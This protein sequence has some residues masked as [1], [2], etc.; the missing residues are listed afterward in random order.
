MKGPIYN[1]SFAFAVRV[2]KLAR[3]LQ[4]DQRE[5]VLSKQVLRS[6]TAIGAL[7][8]EAEHAESKPDFVH[9]MNIGALPDNWTAERL[10]AKHPSKPFNPD[11][12]N[13]FFRAG[14]IEAWGRGI[15]RMCADCAAHGVPEPVLLCEPD[16]MWVEFANR[17]VKSD[18]TIPKTRKTTG[19]KPA[20]IGQ[21]RAHEAHEAHEAHVEGQVQIGA[22]E[23][24][25]LRICAREPASAKDL[26][27]TVGYAR[28][29]GN[30]RRSLDKLL[31][32]Q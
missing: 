27:A 8:R 1:K 4:E 19:A 24:V 15:E 7:V 32:E 31:E 17:T 30:F 2:V 9:K 28:R 12:A 22:V 20:K 29:T 21:G 11:V 5:F 16:G 14:T 18:E 25:M 3:F 10:K 26:R 23:L 6:G 13:V